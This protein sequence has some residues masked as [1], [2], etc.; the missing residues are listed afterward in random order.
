[1]VKDVLLTLWV[2]FLLGMAKLIN[3]PTGRSIASMM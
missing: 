1:M 3:W 2:V